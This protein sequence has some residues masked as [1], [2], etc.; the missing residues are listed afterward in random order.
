MPESQPTKVVGQR[1]LAFLIDSLLAGVV[2]AILWFALT[3]RFD[4][5]TS[6]GGG[7]EI[8][9]TRYAFSDA[10]AWKRTLW[11]ILTI[12]DY[13]VVFV[14]LPG[15]RGTSPGRR[16]T[17]IRLVKGDGSSPGVG[18]ALL[19]YIVLIFVDSFPYFIPYL[20]GL[21]LMLT[22]KSNQR[23]GDLAAKTFT[24]REELAGRPV[25][26]LAAAPAQP[27]G[28]PPP[29]PQPQAPAATP[30]GWYDDPHGQ[31]RL[32]WWDGQTWTDQTSP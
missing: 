11:A 4:A 1:V 8:G 32:R 29:Q 15:L 19:R 7:F 16:L 22:T 14:I 26:Q 18:R 2:M 13:L 17:G 23:L 24:V 6:A 28:F 21:I 10:D 20:V 30:P 5:D 9:D 25:E 3:N 12:V 27:A 31:A